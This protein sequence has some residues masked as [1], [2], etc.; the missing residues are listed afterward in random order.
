MP[1]GPKWRLGGNEAK[2]RKILE[3]GRS[4]FWLPCQLDRDV[5]GLEITEDGWE[6]T[7]ETRYSLVDSLSHVTQ[8]EF[9]QEICRRQVFTGNVVKDD[10]ET[11][12]IDADHPLRHTPLAWFCLENGAED[13]DSGLAGNV[14]FSTPIGVESDIA[15]QGA[16]PTHNFYLVEMADLASS[17]ACRI[18]VTKNSYPS[19]QPYDPFKRGGPWYW[20]RRGYRNDHGEWERDRH[21]VLKQFRRFYGQT[22]YNSTSCRVEFVREASPDQL[23]HW[24]AVHNYAI[25]FVSQ[26]QGEKERSPRVVD[27]HRI[28][29]MTKEEAFFAFL[30]WVM[31]PLGYINAVVRAPETRQTDDGLGA[32]KRQLT[33]YQGQQLSEMEHKAL[34]A[35]NY[36]C[37]TKVNWMCS[38]EG[39]LPLE[40]SLHIMDQAL[41]DDLAKK[42][43]SNILS[44]ADCS[45]S[46]VFLQNLVILHKLLSDES[47]SAM[48][49]RILGY[50]NDRE[51]HMSA[52]RG[53]MS[54]LVEGGLH[55]KIPSVAK[56]VTALFGQ[57]FVGYMEEMAK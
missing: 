10:H 12:M 54:R 26:V 6:E 44:A 18:L 21:Y 46:A 24:P 57:L 19:L 32:T 1:F 28:P 34:E 56:D 2:A 42:I 40:P 37:A 8:L 41:T 55:E 11:V 20:D 27:V 25:S 33:G 35:F 52:M 22:G 9:A 38:P 14:K 36:V 17:C 49:K 29:D 4:K 43:A 48:V 15:R 53:E 7:L 31:S 3:R 5:A 45:Q 13:E 47:S 23:E 50:S 30:V 16:R 51:G 39:F